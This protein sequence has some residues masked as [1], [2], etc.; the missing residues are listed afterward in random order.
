MS[1]R[2]DIAKLSRE[3][4]EAWFHRTWAENDQLRARVIELEA[5]LA[6]VRGTLDAMRGV[7]EAEEPAPHM[8]D[9]PPNAPR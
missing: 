1:D 8:I 3:A 4:V 2:P 6:L 9:H 5:A 7:V